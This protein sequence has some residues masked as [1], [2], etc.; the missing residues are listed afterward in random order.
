MSFEI[1][2]N[3]KN[4]FAEAEKKVANKKPRFEQYTD[5][6][7]DLST[8]KLKF[9]L[10][11][12]ANEV[13]LYRILVAVLIIISAALWVFSLI[14]WGQ[15]LAVG[16]TKD[17]QL[18]RDLSQFPNYNLRN[19][20]DAPAPIQI[21]NADLLPAG[22]NNS[23]ATAEVS[24]PN[25]RWLAM[26][27]YYFVVGG[28]NTKT[29]NGFLLPGEDKLLVVFGL[30]GSGQ[31]AATLVI[32]NVTWQKISPHDVLDTAAWQAARLNFIVS[33]FMFKRAGSDP[34]APTAQ[35]ISF[36]LINNSPFGYSQPKFVVGFYFGQ[37]LVG[38]MPLEL[39]NFTSQQTAN[40]DLRSFVGNLTVD[41][42]RIFPLINLYDPQ[43]YLAPPQ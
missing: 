18:Y 33:N 3:Q 35:T 8:G 25:N 41:D 39:N 7:G 24:N 36:N 37:V 17:Q 12:T 29:Q 19:Q 23:N 27:T 13:S 2:Q 28:Q 40:I 42:V 11:L 22:V 38:V 31:G 4:A 1:N 30:S 16:L 43:V 6:T 21:I 34:D 32:E 14:S 15:Y 20:S 26:F 5:P 10:W 9:G